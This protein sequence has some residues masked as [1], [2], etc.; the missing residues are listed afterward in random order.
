MLG[1]ST[2]MS[3]K[4]TPYMKLGHPQACP[5]G[6]PGSGPWEFIFYSNL[7]FLVCA[8]APW[9]CRG[10]LYVRQGLFFCLPFLFFILLVQYK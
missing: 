2:S 3:Y 10:M 1:I 8:P 6:A 5:Q 9:G 7:S 4:Y